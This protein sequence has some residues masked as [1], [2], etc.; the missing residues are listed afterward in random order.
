MRSLFTV[1]IFAFGL[2]ISGQAIA[3]MP[4]QP[5]ELQQQLEAAQRGDVKA[6]L[7]VGL[8]Y[9]TGKGVV[10]DYAKAAQWTE[11]AARQG[12]ANTTSKSGY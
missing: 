5:T 7:N 9:G 12:D 8:M 6:Q 4:S 2:A 10:Q 3:N 1:L 11:K